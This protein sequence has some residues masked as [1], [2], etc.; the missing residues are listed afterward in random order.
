MTRKSPSRTPE[1]IPP[2]SWS[3]QSGYHK[4]KKLDY[5]L[6]ETAQIPSRGEQKGKKKWGRAEKEGQNVLTTP[7]PTTLMAFQL[8]LFEA[9]NVTCSHDPCLWLLRDW[10]TSFLAHI[11]SYFGVIWIGLCAVSDLYILGYIWFCLWGTAEG[12]GG[13]GRWCWPARWAADQAGTIDNWIIGSVRSVALT[14]SQPLGGVC[15]ICWFMQLARRVVFLR[16]FF[17]PTN[18]F[19]KW[20]GWGLVL[21]LSCVNLFTTKQI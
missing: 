16:Y 13:E 18:M 1:T 5:P 20:W 14:L 21:L 17:W 7:H 11:E 10:E 2:A 19:G 8:N 6:A 15:G 9:Y 12:P 3:A 4:Q